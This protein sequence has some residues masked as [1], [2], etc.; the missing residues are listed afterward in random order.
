MQKRIVFK[1]TDHS[2]NIE[3]F[4]LKKL[5]KIETIIE[6]ERTPHNIDMVIEIHP[7]HAHN[8]VELNLDFANVRLHAHHEGPDIY[9][10][11]DGVIAKM[12]EEIRKA[13][14]KQKDLDKHGNNKFKSA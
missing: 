2:E 7:D 4:A 10:E 11:I 13:Q 5:E 1:N 12:I 8:R 9:K 14:D 6:N 3:N